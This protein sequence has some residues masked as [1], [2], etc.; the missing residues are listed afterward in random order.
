MLQTDERTPATGTSR[1]SWP[2]IATLL[3]APLVAIAARTASAP[4][5]Q[6]DS[7]KVDNARY[8]DE[9]ASAS[10]R[11]DIGSG[12]TLLSAA[13]FA[14]AAFAIGSIAR[15]RSPRTGMA[16]QLLAGFGA[17][18]L[19]AFSMVQAIAGQAARSEDREAMIE[20]FDRVNVEWPTNLYYLVMGVGALGWL[21]LGLAL[22]RGRTVPRTAA[23]LT[24]IGGA[25]VY[26]TAPGPLTSFVAGS[27]VVALLGFAWTA[28]SAD[29][30]V[31]SG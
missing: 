20:L 16:G 5:F 15:A 6:K 26:L 8:L 19:A 7:D 1:S 10:L 13:L 9:L 2:V 31:V 14:A 18:G 30:R 11:N 4:M 21:L 27:A 22:F 17:F 12:L 25:A 28:K 3:A 29:Q 24:A 23:V